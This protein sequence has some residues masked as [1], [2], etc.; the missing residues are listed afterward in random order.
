MN[1]Y[2]AFW[3]ARLGPLVAPEGARKD[4]AQLALVRADVPLRADVWAAAVWGTAALAAAWGLLLGA[5][6]GAVAAGAI[7]ALLLGLLLALFLGASVAVGASVWLRNQAV[8]RAK[9][10]D[11]NLPHALNYLLALANAGLPAKELWRS[12]AQAKAFGA[13]SREAARIHRDLALFNLD[14]LEALRLAQERSPSRRF[15]EFLQGA[16]SAFQSGVEI[17]SYLRNKGRQFTLEAAEAQ[18]KAIDTMG[19]MA[20]AFL[21]VVV[22]A[23]LFLLILLSV[24][25]IDRG[26][27]VIA[28]GF[29]LVLVFMPMGQL[30]LGAMIRSLNPRVWT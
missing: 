19:V 13:L 3:H 5:L 9:E 30:I 12:L 22:A 10:I 14:L 8:E 6:L 15:G 25:S 26:S 1:A 28:L 17:D 24:M 7:G 4:A 20:E 27:S 11:D 23:P 21:V 18:R 2:L 16:V 29:A